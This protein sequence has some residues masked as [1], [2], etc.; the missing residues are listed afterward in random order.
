[1]VLAGIVRNE[2]VWVARLTVNVRARSGAA[3]YVALPLCDATTV[4]LPAVRRSIEEPLRPPVVHTA[5][6]VDANVTGRL[7]DAVA[8]ATTGDCTIVRLGIAVNVMVWLT[9]LTA[10]LRAT[11]AAGLNAASPP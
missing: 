4:Q 6:V 1:M 3:L 8:E 9:R 2:I 11:G 10:K 7:D 5:G